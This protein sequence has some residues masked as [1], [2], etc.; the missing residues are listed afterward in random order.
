V[1]GAEWA[2]L[3]Y[4]PAIGPQGAWQPLSAI[5]GDNFSVSAIA[6]TQDRVF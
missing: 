6:E 1:F 5:V 3:K 2:E 4:A